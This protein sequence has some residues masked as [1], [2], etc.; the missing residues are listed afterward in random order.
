M[1]DEVVL[2]LYDL[3]MPGQVGEHGIVR[4]NLGERGLDRLR[5]AFWVASPSESLGHSGREL[6]LV[7]T[8]QVRHLPHVVGDGGQFCG[9]ET[10][11]R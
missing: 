7:G 5:I 9:W 11:S 10:D 2:A 4:L 1:C 6:P 8:E 3:T